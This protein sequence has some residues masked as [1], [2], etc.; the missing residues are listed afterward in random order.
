MDCDFCFQEIN[1]KRII[2][3]IIAKENEFPIWRKYG[4]QK[5]LKIRKLEYQN[6]IHLL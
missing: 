6:F 2:L 5:K 3:L 1:K 4:N